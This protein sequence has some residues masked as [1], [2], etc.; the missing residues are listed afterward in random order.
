ML[1]LL[2]HSTTKPGFYVL[3]GLFK[4]DII[5]TKLKFMK[6]VKYGHTHTQ[7]S[8]ITTTTTTTTTIIIK[9]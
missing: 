8:T 7:N 6:L 1:F 9:F 2:L 3:K 5:P 4:T